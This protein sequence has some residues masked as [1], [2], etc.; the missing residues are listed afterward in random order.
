MVAFLSA[1]AP[2]PATP[3]SLFGL[4]W[5]LWLMTLG[6]LVID[7]NAAL[8]FALLPLFVTQ[9]HINLGQ[10]GALATVLLMTSS[11]TQPVF[12]YL[13][14]RYPLF[15][16]SAAG[17]LLAGLGMGLTGFAA[18]YMQMLALVLISG[19]GIAAFHPQA[20][21]QASRASADSQ[22]WGIA[23]FFTGASM[24]TG[25]MSLLIVPLAY[26]F[27]PHATLVTLLP[28]V[29][30][31]ALFVRAYP[32]WIRPAPRLPGSATAAAAIRTVALPLSMLLI[33]SVLR[34]AV[35][36]AYLT[37]LP[38]LVVYR[39]G[40]LGLG[41]IA[42]AA[43]LFSGS[44]GAIVGGAVAHRIGSAPVV[45]VSLIAGLLALLP[46]PW[47]PPPLLVPWMIG[48]GVLMFASEAQVTALAQ[49]LLPAFVGTASSLIMGVGLGLGNAGALVTGAVA[50]RRG[51]QVAMTATT[52]LM[53]GAIAGACVYVLSM[54]GRPSTA[55][56]DA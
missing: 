37:F 16:M 30:A 44:L 34:S 46:V 9:L 6:H 26:R 21:A 20:V 47:L 5:R 43:F 40:S 53:V 32:T 33:V 56:Q 35:L 45:V 1:S 22:E 36:T 27:G 28:A 11:I 51:I 4:R 49:R 12:G 17:L 54:H 41:A 14:D 50:D 23:M 13:H 19:I 10:A 29:I 25:I 15:P 2:V 48:G 42:L 52:L 3:A 38:T 18:S 55:H 7:S 31:A 39:T 8:L 24:G